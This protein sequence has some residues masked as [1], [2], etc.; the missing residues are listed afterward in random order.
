MK[1][2]KSRKVMATLRG[3]LHRRHVG[4]ESDLGKCL[5]ALIVSIFQQ[6][7]EVV[8]WNSPLYGAK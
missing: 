7:R 6:V 5:D 2:H 1:A 8:C 4:L 3:G